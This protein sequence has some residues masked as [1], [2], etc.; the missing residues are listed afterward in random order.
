MAAGMSQGGR[1]DSRLIDGRAAAGFRA[2]AG[3][4][5]RATGG[6]VTGAAVEVDELC[7]ATNSAG[8][9]AGTGVASPVHSE[10]ETRPAG[11]GPGVHWPVSSGVQVGLAAGGPASGRSEE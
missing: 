1:S 5:V 7:G 11:A 8:T 3:A 10:L 2:G 6:L 9:G 4:G